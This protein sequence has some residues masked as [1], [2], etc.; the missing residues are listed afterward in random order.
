MSDEMRNKFIS[1]F[2]RME[3]E[4][5]ACD[6]ERSKTEQRRVYRQLKADWK[7][8]EAEVGYTV[9]EYVIERWATDMVKR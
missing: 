8:L 6:G 1:L 3:P 7:A 2:F 4:N 5:L 9:S